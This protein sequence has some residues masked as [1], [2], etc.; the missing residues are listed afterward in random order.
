MYQGYCINNNRPQKGSRC[1]QLR[2]DVLATALRMIISHIANILA[3][4]RRSI[5]SDLYQL[6]MRQISYGAN[7]HH[8]HLINCSVLAAYDCKLV[9]L[10]FQPRENPNKPPRVT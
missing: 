7:D 6:L 5:S 8:T 2:R 3:K 10:S 9:G 4:L 1:I